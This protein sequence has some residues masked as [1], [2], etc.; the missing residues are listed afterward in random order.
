MVTKFTRLS[1]SHDEAQPMDDTWWSAL[2]AEEDRYITSS[3]TRH[4][5]RNSPSSQDS[6]E[7]ND[8]MTEAFKLKPGVMVYR[9]S[10]V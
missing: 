6:E 10:V 9:K 4:T 1:G 8:E 3:R 5:S 7:K 2:L